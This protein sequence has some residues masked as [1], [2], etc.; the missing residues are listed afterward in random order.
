MMRYSL[1]QQA[2]RLLTDTEPS[3]LTVGGAEYLSS[4]QYSVF[5]NRAADR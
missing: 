5:L 2:S 1:I 3:K 4:E